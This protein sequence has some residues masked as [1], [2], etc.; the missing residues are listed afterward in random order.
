MK[1]TDIIL[2]MDNQNGTE[3]NYLCTF[4]GFV[5]N[6]L[7]KACA[8]YWEVAEMVQ[9]LDATKGKLAKYC[10]IY[11]DTGN[12]IYAKYCGSI[13][14]LQ[15]FLLGK[16][17]SGVSYTFEESFCDKECLKAMERM[18][19]ES[20]G[21]QAMDRYPHYKRLE[22]TFK[23]GEILHNFNGSDYRVL[24]KLSDNNLLLMDVATGSFTVGIGVSYFAK[25]PK[26]EDISSE[27][28]EEAIEWEHGVYLGSSLFQIDFPSIQKEYG[29]A[30]KHSSFA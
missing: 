2:V 23:Q 18:G 11:F 28:C 24:E 26:C 19:I 22:K 27:L 30:R 6:I 14:E 25:Y 5:K 10:E 12:I 15:I 7:S 17:N 1:I 29:K 13:S 8:N 20:T 21:A 4:E 16:L 9:E 3:K